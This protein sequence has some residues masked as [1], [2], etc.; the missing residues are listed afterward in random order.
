LTVLN[1]K[2]GRALLLLVVLVL[3]VY[4]NTFHAS[5]HLDDR[6]NILDNQNV[7]VD[8]LSLDEWARSAAPPFTD[9][10]RAPS[11]W[12]DLYR[13]VAML[14]FAF[15][16]FLGGSSVFGY[17]VVNIGLH[18]ATT[19]LLF[20]TCL[21][22]LS[23][24]NNHGR[25]E[26]H[27]LP[28]AFMA[29][30]L[31]ALHP[32]QTQAVTYIVQRMAVLAAFFYLA[33]I[34]LYLK[35]R[36]AQSI[37][38]KFLFF[39][40][41]VLSYLLALGSKQNAV[42]LPM[43]WLLVE[44]VFY[45]VPGFWNQEKG[46]WLVIAVICGLVAFFLLVLLSWQA[47]PLS[48]IMKGYQRRPFN[49]P[50]RVLTEFRVLIFHLGQLFYP[51]PQQFSI[52]HDFNISTSLITPL[53][54]LGALLLI[55][56]MIVGGILFMHQWPLLSFAVLFF[57]LGHSVESTVIALELV[58]E[59]RNY[60]PSLFLFLPVSAGVILL[61][62]KYR[63]EN[64]LVYLMLVMFSTLIVLGIGLG[65]HIRN[66]VWRNEKILWQDAMQKAP[67]LARPLQNLALALEKEW[68]LDAALKLYQKALTLKDP[69]PELSQFISLS[70]MGNI[71]RKKEDY[72][73]AVHYLAKAV[74][75]E[76]GPY[77]ERA[78]LNL[79]LSL[80]NVQ[81]EEK[82]LAH[83][84]AGLRQQKGNIRF[85]AVKGFILARQGK[86]DQAL[87]HLRRVLKLNTYDREGL[88]NLSIVLSSEGYFKRSE[89]FLRRAEKKYPS[90]LIVHL[91]LL[92]NALA[93]KNHNQAD[94]YMAVITQKFSMHDL[95]RYLSARS[96][97]YLYFDGTL[98]PIDD[99][100]VIPYLLDYLRNKA[101]GLDICSMEKVE[102]S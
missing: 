51:V 61:T 83:V 16:W 64:R 88:I 72:S 21:S 101:T 35:S 71:Y 20:F 27:A 15:N 31:W 85:L 77:K 22:L 82:A 17:H 18:C 93:M 33:G 75:V 48:A 74:H 86:I 12:S 49:M 90:N 67:N 87:A 70:N 46:R 94:Q 53:S 69:S 24:P 50:Q 59:H 43:T 3:I 30:A 52:M 28:I 102:N 91:G 57:F 9:P 36:N 25:Y 79:A 73:Q 68:K 37:G 26:G 65:S 100:V 5:W 47:D 96:R 8:S 60:L 78:R 10:G 39:G 19:V 29:T 44:I 95:I 45:R 11:G 58:F 54:T 40:M 84:N 1:Y 34:F 4:G 7:H 89:W 81:E 62:E 63:N 42:T 23:A 97:G 55:I 2:Y 98:V 38:R 32:I 41:A 13:P 6:T 76:K 66:S 56:I 80:L 92:Q 99:S 14:T